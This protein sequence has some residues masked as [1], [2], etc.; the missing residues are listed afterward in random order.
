[1]AKLFTYKFLIASFVIAVVYVVSTIYLMNFRLVQN[2]IVGDYPLGYKGRLLIDLLGGMWTAMTG[3]GLSL[4]IITSILTGADLSLLMGHI[5]E[6]RKQGKIR[7][8]VGGSSLLGI[9][10]SGCAACGLPVLALL[11]LSGS[12]AYLPLRGMELSYLSV[13]LLL[14]SFY[15][16]A[17][18]DTRQLC[19]I[20]VNK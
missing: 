3:K 14:F 10:G 1:M 19:N 12:V 5:K 17:R 2:T 16:L 18:T 8:M 4:L 7:F 13:L 15:I 6:L 9:V 20:N 11:G